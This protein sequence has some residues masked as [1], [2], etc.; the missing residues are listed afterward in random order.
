MFI[1]PDSPDQFQRR[2]TRE[3]AES[4]TKYWWVLLVEG[5][6]LIVAG[7]LIF[8]IDWSVR[9]LSIF[10]G[11][12]FVLHGISMAFVREFGRTARLTNGVSGVAS[13]AAGV[14]I[15]A[16][17]HPGL[18]A[19]GIFLGSWLIVVGTITISGSFAARGVIPDWWMWLILGLLEVPLGVLALADPGGTLAALITVAVIWAVAVGVMYVVAS[20]QLKRL[21]QCVEQL[22]NEASSNSH[23][24][25][26]T[27]D[28]GRRSPSHAV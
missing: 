17:P 4:V 22:E 24:R 28:I 19:V 16:W 13:V 5:L 25:D 21:P 27:P 18:T 20:F 3:L 9:S 26:A 11:A 10:I 15:I 12:L 1:G 23:R 6:T 2:L 8:G 7:V 14:A